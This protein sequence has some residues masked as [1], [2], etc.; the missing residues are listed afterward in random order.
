MRQR[1]SYFRNLD[2]S[3][4]LLLSIPFGVAAFTAQ[5][6]HAVDHNVTDLATL[7]AAVDAV[8]ASSTNDRIL[9]AAG[10]I[11]LTGAALDNANAS[12]DLD[13]TK[14]NGDLE[15]IGAGMT[16]TILDGGGIDRV[17]HILNTTSGTITIRNLTIRNGLATDDGTATP[18][19][20][21]GGILQQGG[22]LVLEGVRV[23][24]NVAQGEIGAPGIDGNISV[25][26]GGAGDTGGA[27][28]GGGLYA[29]AG[30]RTITNCEFLENVA[31]GGT[32]GVGGAGFGSGTGVGGVGG[33]AGNGGEAVG[34]AIYSTGGVLSISGTYFESNSALGG[35]GGTGGIGGTSLTAAGYAGGN[36]GSGGQAFGGGIYFNGATPVSIVDSGFDSNLAQGGNG[37]AG[38]SGQA[39]NNTGGLGGNGGQGAAGGGGSLVIIGNGASIVDGDLRSSYAVGGSGGAGGNGG[40]APNP[41]AAGNGGNGAMGSGAAVMLTVGGLSISRTAVIDCIAR[42]GGGGNGGNAGIGAGAVIGA[43]GGHGGFASEARGGAIS[44]NST[45]DLEVLS[46][47][48]AYCRAIGGAGGNGGNGSGGTMSAGTGGQGR[49]GSQAWGGALY[50]ISGTSDITN[51][52]IANNEATG[53]DGGDGGNAGDTVSVGAPGGDA[54]NAGITYG[55]GISLPG[56]TLTISNSTVAG[57]VAQYGVPG[58]GGAG[59]AGAPA[60]AAGMNG[61]TVGSNFGGGVYVDSG[62]LTVVSSIVANNT[63]NT[64]PDMFCT[65]ATVNNSIVEDTSDAIFTGTGNLNVDP[66]LGP[67]QFNGGPTITMAIASNSPARN[68]GSNPL[69]LT[70]DQRGQARDDGNGVDMGAYERQPNTS[71]GGGKKKKKDEGCST[72]TGNGGWSLLAA[73][74]SLAAL[75]WRRKRVRQ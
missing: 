18:A 69:S 10:T 3:R 51:S 63:A 73:L 39:V 28:S 11:T 31:Q 74:G 45:G 19:S 40:N 55:G 54:G 50:Q 36:G 60:G 49:G 61:I 62:A 68:T 6:L 2:R 65:A 30:G 29:T 33:N 48:I 56:G 38:G 57:N 1:A 64:G 34:G 59:G 52:T 20:L 25:P 24:Q 8:N 16:T 47:T 66:L 67:L 75:V 70:T 46:S 72:G 32:G 37:G 44:H 14:A 7:R 53:G 26:N 21:G 42:G 4:A 15:I 43:V 58:S 9:I 22:S 17:L 13:I 12:G 41:G 27:A 35:N 5:N 23:A 71:S